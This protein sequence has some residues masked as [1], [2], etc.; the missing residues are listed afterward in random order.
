MIILEY[1]SLEEISE[2]FNGIRITRY[3]DEKN[4]QKTQKVFTNRQL[5]NSEE[6]LNSEDIRITS[7]IDSKFYS[8][9][10]DILLQVIG[11]T[12]TTLITNEVGIIIPMNY[13]IVRVHENFNPIFV[14]YVLKSARF[15]DM[16]E[17]LSG[18]SNSHFV[19]IQDL[20]KI[21]VKIPDLVIQQKYAKLM[22][23]LDERNK[24]EYKKLKVNNKI[25]TSIISNKLGD[26]YV[27]F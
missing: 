9:K 26:K 24:L 8:Q 12:K 14:Y 5:E 17:K 13:I 21:K 16:L 20:K 10:N 22:Q 6:I 2:I 23:L 4:T 3:I 11:T 1:L 27:K 18:G 25:Q 7:K 19:K 15:A